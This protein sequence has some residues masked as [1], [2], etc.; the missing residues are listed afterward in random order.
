MRLTYCFLLS[1]LFFSFSVKAQNLTQT[2]RGKVVDIDTKSPLI[3]ANVVVLNS[4]PFLGVTTDFDG[5]FNLKEVPIGRVN[6]KISYLGYEDRVIPNIVL[7][8]AKEMVLT[9]EMSESVVKMTEIE[10]TATKHKAETINEMAVTSTRT[11]SVE[12]TSR[13]A[14]SINDPARMASNFA[15]V[16]ADAQGD[17]TIVVRGNSPKGVK[18]RLEGIEIP[19]P[20]HFTDEGSTGGPIS[21]LNSSML[22]NSEFL[23]GA[24]APEYGNAYSGVLDINLRNG[25]NEKRE[26]AFSAGVLGIDFTAEGPF[27]KG[28]NGSYLINYRYSSLGILTD[29]KIVDFG[30]IPRYQDASFKLMLPTQNFGHFT[31]FGLYGISNI[32]DVTKDEE[33]ENNPI[34]YKSDY[35]SSLST[36]GLTHALTINKSSYLR[37]AVSY[38]TNG[39]RY[40]EYETP[41]Q[42]LMNDYNDDLQKSSLRIQSILHHKI[43]AK[44]KFKIGAFY[45]QDF[46]NY[47]SEVYLLNESK[48]YNIHNKKG[49]T[50]LA[51][52]FASWRF[53]PSNTLTFVGGLHSSHFVLNG[54]TTIEPRAS[55]KWELAPNQFLNFGYGKHSKTESLLTYF[56]KA[57]DSDELINKDIKMLKAHHFVVGYENRLT[58][59]INFKTEAYYQHL[60]NIP[61]IDDKNSY[62]STINH[63]DAFITVPLANK[64][65]GRN[66]GIEITLERFFSDG[67]YLMSTTSLYNSKFT[68]GD[69]IEYNTRWNG[70]YVSNLLAGKEWTYGKSERRRT[71][72]ISGKV[73]LL[74]GNHYTEILLDESIAKGETVLNDSQ[75]FAAKYKDIFF[76]NVNLSLKTNRPKTSHVFKIE[77]QNVSNNQATV[78]QYYN[79]DTKTIINNKQL[80]LIPNI[81]YRIEF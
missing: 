31:L 10:V 23:T 62:Q 26:Y 77:I 21:A 7:N 4:D 40:E 24:F 20:N 12:E 45:T 60:N 78:S 71:F 2:I 81:L 36:T 39:S 29:A 47:F 64:G 3:G 6:L 69:G 14:G 32:H 59:N 57:E 18:W 34:I 16:V 35:Y 46:F 53:R 73:T 41:N 50:G 63:Y 8:S 79:P 54:E 44:H 55:V 38:S 27:K 75:P 72:G 74:G 37:S 30:G 33:L 17:N 67:Y 43:N 49:N 1:L 51:E 52:A 65:R 66:Y 70:N 28:Y 19:N 68:A 25:N 15:G 56:S 5:K 42:E 76:A 61:I 48:W 80:G 13:Y 58:K 22:A 11:F 9:V